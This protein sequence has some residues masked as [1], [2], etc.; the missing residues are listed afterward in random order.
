MNLV[1]IIVDSWRQDHCGCYG[2]DWIHTPHL[3]ALAAQST[4]F[5]RA[6]PESLLT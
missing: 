1:L 6:Y 5:T 2:N 3:D 4:V